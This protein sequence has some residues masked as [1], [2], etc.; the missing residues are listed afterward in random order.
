MTKTLRT[1]KSPSCV[2]CFDVRDYTTVETNGRL[3]NGVRQAVS[4]ANNSKGEAG[5]DETASS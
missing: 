3:R 1:L 4:A 5:D 2:R